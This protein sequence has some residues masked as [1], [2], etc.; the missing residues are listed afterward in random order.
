MFRSLLAVTPVLALLTGTTVAQTSQNVGEPTATTSSKPTVVMENVGSA[1]STNSAG[2]GG[3]SL[4]MQNGKGT[5]A[6]VTP[7]G[8]PMVV[9]TP[10]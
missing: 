6:L 4:F 5:S 10:R 9:L 3:E 2:S 8:N 1:A 7:G